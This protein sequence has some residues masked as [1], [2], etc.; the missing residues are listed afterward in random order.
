M[1]KIENYK[2]V[3][4]IIF[5]SIILIIFYATNKYENFNDISSENIKIIENIINTI[6]LDNI[7]FT[8]HKPIFI[9]D[10]I[11]KYIIEFNDTH[12]INQ[13]N[14]Y[15]ESLKNNNF[16]NLYNIQTESKLYYQKNGILNRGCI[17][18]K[19]SSNILTADDH[20]TIFNNIPIIN[21]NQNYPKYNNVICLS[22]KNGDQYYHFLYDYLIRLHIFE[23]LNIDISEMYIHVNIK[24]PYIIELLAL[25]G[26]DEDKIIDDTIE[27]D[28]LYIPDL[29]LG[30]NMSLYHAIYWF[31]S[32]ILDNSSY[33]N[34]NKIILIKRTYSRQLVNYEELYDIILKYANDNELELYI[35][36]DSNLPSLKDQFKIF[37]EAV[38][39]CGSHGACLN[40]L[41]ACHED[42]KVIELMDKSHHGYEFMKLS[43]YLNL[44]YFGLH[45]EDFIVNCDE[46]SEILNK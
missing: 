10:K 14:I 4:F 44:S 20:H 41:I 16:N 38:I 32:K 18:L 1:I 7:I 19:N 27:F 8:N 11:I 21:L 13:L 26:L 23:L 37:S 33:L 22:G 17:F 2:K 30:Y 42:T 3:Y 12:S 45:T 15:K 35:H 9:D 39:V 46:V 6:E 31:R 43:W 29:N 40:S 36:D 34:R 25:L 5:I 24:I 28:N